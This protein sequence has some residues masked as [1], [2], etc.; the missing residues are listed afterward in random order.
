[1][2]KVTKLKNSRRAHRTHANRLMR[3]INDLLQNINLEDEFQVTELKVFKENYKHQFS[4]IKM[5][6]DD[7]IS[8][9]EEDAVEEEL[10]KSLQEK[11]IFYTVLKKVKLYLNKVI[12]E[13]ASSH[14]RR[15]LLPLRQLKRVI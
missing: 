14:T 5:L 3:S 1:M 12:M 15:Y 9:L 2:D 4:K 10:L 7:I 13:T 6:D 8:H 11:E